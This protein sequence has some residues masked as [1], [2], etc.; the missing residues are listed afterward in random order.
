M[1]SKLKAAMLAGLIGLGSLAAVPATAQADSFY[2]G[3]GDGPARFGFHL[4]PSYGHYPH[5][6]DD[7][8]WHRP[9]HHARACTP[10]RA[11]AKAE[12]L[13]L[14]RIHVERVNRRHIHVS[15]RKW[16]N[17][18]VIVVFARAPRCPIVRW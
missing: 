17:Q 2:L 15:G 7:Y 6:Y 9:P 8:R 16:G 11:V 18:R 14:R 3:F 12:R 1:F 5:H 10:R 13:G 4:G